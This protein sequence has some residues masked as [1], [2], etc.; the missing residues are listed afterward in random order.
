MPVVVSGV[1]GDDD[2]KCGMVVPVLA[3]VETEVVPVLAMMMVTV[4]MMRLR[5]MQ[6]V[7]LF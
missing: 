1:N 5:L 4:M 6:N 3:L 7:S 2:G